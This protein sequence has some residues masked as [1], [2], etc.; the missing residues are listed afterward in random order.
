MSKR[1]KYA[2]FG[3]WKTNFLS[4]SK[5]HYDG[6]WEVKSG[7]LN[8]Y[9]N[10]NSKKPKEVVFTTIHEIVEADVN[11]LLARL[12]YPCHT[13]RSGDRTAN[14]R[15][16]YVVPYFDEELVLDTCLCHFI[17]SASEFNF[18]KNEDWRK[19]I[20]FYIHNWFPK[21]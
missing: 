13:K 10:Y 5:G 4:P 7:V 1:F 16:K 2:Q 21:A 6:E 9:A 11:K 20:D 12:S 8:V 17:T 15:V 19:S 14:Y 3:D 18:R